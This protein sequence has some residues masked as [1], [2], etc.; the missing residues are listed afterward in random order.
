MTSLP[1]AL[2]ASTEQKVP[3]TSVTNQNLKLKPKLHPA[4]WIDV[5]VTF[6]LQGVLLFQRCTATL[7]G[8]WAHDARQGSASK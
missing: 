3:E 2:N 8:K 7:W 5:T 4:T 6:F 1:L